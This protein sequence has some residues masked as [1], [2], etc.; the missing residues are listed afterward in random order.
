MGRLNLFRLSVH[1]F[2]GQFN[3]SLD[4]LRLVR[5]ATIHKHPVQF[6][7]NICIRLAVH[8]ETAAKPPLSKSHY[9]V[10]HLP[11]CHLFCKKLITLCISSDI[12]HI[13]NV[14][15]MFSKSLHCLCSATYI[16]DVGKFRIMPV[17]L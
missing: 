4:K 6:F 16:N 3:T 1:F 2:I 5:K 17:F 13:R 9:H 14:I 11:L 12:R 8:I 7:Q 10:Y 15:P